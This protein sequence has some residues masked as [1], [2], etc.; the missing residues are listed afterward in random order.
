MKLSL[1][2]L[3]YVVLANTALAQDN[4]MQG[5]V[6]P[7]LFGAPTP[8]LEDHIQQPQEI[9]PAPV[10]TPEA[11]PETPEI[12]FVIA[13]KPKRKPPVPVQEKKIT[14]AETPKAQ[15]ELKPEPEPQPEKIEPVKKVETPEIEK[16][17]LKPN[18]EGVVKGPKTM[19]SVKKENVQTEVTYETKEQSS[20]DM[21]ERVQKKAQRKELTEEEK[22]AALPNAVMPTFKDQ[23]DG[24]RKM[25]IYFTESQANL[26]PRQQTILSKGI[27]PELKNNKNRLLVQ[28]YA[29]PQETGMSADRRLSLSRALAIRR[30]LLENNISS[31][32]I[33]VRALG[34][35]S[36]IQ[37]LDR[38]ELI[39]IP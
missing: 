13:P 29:M 28:A 2:L 31:A 34:S 9:S 18:T 5:Y 21:M 32:R 30:Y 39:L 38:V 20:T 33:D 19:P 15:P 16:V 24:T 35:Q 17:E 25:V 6:P 26:E 8:P 23:K 10:L 12:K 11:K 22:L 27:I 4:N 14:A 7:P 36:N 3:V 1:F 37:P